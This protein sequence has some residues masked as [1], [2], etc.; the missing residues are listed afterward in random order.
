MAALAAAAAVGAAVD[1]VAAV[2]AAAAA[3][4]AAADLVAIAAAVVEL[5][6]E[7]AAIDNSNMQA[8]L[9]PAVRMVYL[10]VSLLLWVLTQ[11]VLGA[12]ALQRL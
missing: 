9:G 6:V 3:A 8:L 5:M 2:A 4:T 7:A 1:P 12:V 11:H 10:Q